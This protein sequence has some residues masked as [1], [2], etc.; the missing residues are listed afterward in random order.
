MKKAARI[1]AIAT[2]ALLSVACSKEVIRPIY[3]SQATS[4]HVAMMPYNNQGMTVAGSTNWYYGEGAGLD[5]FPAEGGI[6]YAERIEDTPGGNSPNS[7]STAP[8]NE[9]DKNRNSSR[10]AGSSSENRAASNGKLQTNSGKGS[11]GKGSEGLAE[12]DAGEG[13][14]QF[15]SGKTTPDGAPLDMAD[16]DL[17]ARVHFHFN[18]TEELYDSSIKRLAKLLDGDPEAEELHIIGYTDDRG[19][20]AVNNPISLG[21]AAYIKQEISTKWPNLEITIEGRGACPRIADNTTR[22]GRVLNRRAEA[23]A[24]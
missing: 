15:C 6:I 23:Y 12:Y 14:S 16:A 18:E 21:R 3:D 22:T 8:A 17:I 2:T 13:R 4:R 11:T 7:T 19:T 10:G 24:F 20:D 9:G 1:T 5:A